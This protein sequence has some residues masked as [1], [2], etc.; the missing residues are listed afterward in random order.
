M[1]LITTENNPDP[2]YAEILGYN[3]RIETEVI[4][5]YTLKLENVDYPV[6]LQVYYRDLSL[7]TITNMFLK[8]E[9]GIETVS[10]IQ[11]Q[12]I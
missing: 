3:Q 1:L 5:E 4:K 11:S 7:K 9:T 2:I 12:L 6:L 10:E 8:F